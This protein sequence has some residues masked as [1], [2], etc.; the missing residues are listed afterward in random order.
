VRNDEDPAGLKAQFSKYSG[1]F[2]R[3]A[4]VHHLIR[5]ALKDTTSVVQVDKKTAFAV[6]SLIDN[7]LAPHARRIHSYLGGNPTRDN[8]RRI[9]AWI[10]EDPPMTEF[11]ARDLRRK[12]WSGLTE[13]HQ[14][15]QALDFL[16]NNAS[17]IRCTTNLPNP[18]G[19]R[20]TSTYRINPLV[21][22]R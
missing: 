15:N 3:L 16:E 9:A 20:P 5:Y 7:Y 14:V 1:L 18:R 2:A 8:A 12:Q 11:S 6:Q 13:Q 10:A 4:I 19:G 22:R 17:W 21:H